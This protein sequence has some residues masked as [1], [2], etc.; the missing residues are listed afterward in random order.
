MPCLLQPDLA[1][2]ITGMLLE[3]DNSY[4]LSMLNSQDTLSTKVN[5]CVQALQGQQAAKNKTADLESLH[6]SFQNSSGVNAN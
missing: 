6:P 2:K 5:E 1:S 4:L 3:L